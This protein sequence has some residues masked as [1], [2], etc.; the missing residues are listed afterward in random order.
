MKTKDKT[1]FLSVRTVWIP[2][3]VSVL[4]IRFV[5]SLHCLF[6]CYFSVCFGKSLKSRV[7]YIRIATSSSI[8]T[9]IKLKR[10]L[11]RVT[12]DI[13][14]LAIIL[15]TFLTIVYGYFK[16]S[17]GYWKARGVP[18]DEPSIPYGNIKVNKKVCSKAETIKHLYDKYK[19][20]GA[21]I[22]GFYHFIRPIAIIFDVELIKRIFI[23]DCNKFADR[24]VYYNEVDEPI[25]AHSSFD[26]LDGERWQK[27]CTTTLVPA[28]SSEKLKAMFPSIVKVGE[29]FRDCLVDAIGK[30]PAADQLKGLEIREWCS[31]F[32][33]DGIACVFGIESK[34][35]TDEHAKFQQNEMSEFITKTVTESIEQRE[36]KKI[37]RDDLMGILMKLTNDEE[38]PLTLNEFV[39]QTCALFEAGFSSSATVLTFCLYELAIQFDIQC[40][41]RK[42][43]NE[44]CSK[45]N[46][47]FTYE[48][49]VDMT[50][51]DQIIEGKH[52]RIFSPFI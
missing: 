2:I 19:P 37:Q 51:L 22:C 26:A 42:V 10:G 50:Y 3:F 16:Y 47:R 36:A 43:I 12:M 20:T 48:M 23:K 18:C 41:A 24:N 39:A 45:L 34:T 27:L 7:F 5:C 38:T 32:M 15:L 11:V 40:K 25:S 52:T 14:N 28:F 35:L 13:V 29:Q 4:R 33:T 8:S 46:G 30:Q 31:R 6:S 49:V 21:K 9:V 1:K 44:A 17:Y